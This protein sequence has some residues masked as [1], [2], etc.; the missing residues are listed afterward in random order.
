MKR[1][2]F[3]SKLKHGEKWR[4]IKDVRV[5]A[6]ARWLK[7]NEI[8]TPD[9]PEFAKRFWVEDHQDVASSDCV[10]VYAED[11]EHLRGALVEAG[12]ALALDIPVFVIGSHPDYGTWQ[13]H[14]TVRR[15]KTLEDAFA[16]LE[17]LP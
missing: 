1:V 13:Y 4:D 17:K 9:T 14:P 8:G 16:I 15:C 2:Y 10:I 12:I 3:A 6:H 11:G 7:H 5:H